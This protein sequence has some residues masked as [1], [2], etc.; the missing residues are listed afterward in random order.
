MDLPRRF[1][2]ITLE[3]TE[4][5]L[6]YVFDTDGKSRVNPNMFYTC[7]LIPRMVRSRPSG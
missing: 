1:G 6:I 3:D 7:V 2:G 4:T 5:F